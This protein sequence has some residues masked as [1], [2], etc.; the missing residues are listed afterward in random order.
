MAMDNAAFVFDAAEK[1]GIYLDE[2]NALRLLD[3][4]IAGPTNELKNELRQF[5][6]SK[7]SVV[8]LRVTEIAG[9]T[10]ASH[11]SETWRID[12]AKTFGNYHVVVSE[13][14]HNAPLDTVHEI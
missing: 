12:V 13:E 5:V 3:P 6:E 9:C 1:I 10:I 4:D 7:K 11:L 8:T 14:R 2:I